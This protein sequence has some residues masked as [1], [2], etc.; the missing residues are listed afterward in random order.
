[1]NE[2]IIIYMSFVMFSLCAFFIIILIT[3]NVRSLKSQKRFHEI[4]QEGRRNLLKATI[5]GQE[6]ERK[7]IAENL[8]DDIGPLLSSLKLQVRN[9][10]YDPPTQKV[11]LDTID[12]AVGEIRRVLQKLSPLVF[13]ELGL[14]ESVRHICNEFK[15]LSKLA[16]VLKWD[17]TIEASLDREKKLAIFRI[18][19]EALNNILKHAHATD[20]EIIALMKGDGDWQIDITDNGI[21][22]QLDAGKQIGLGMSSMLARAESMNAKLIFTSKGKGASLV[23]TIPN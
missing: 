13:E 23:L 16:L 7:S 18:I 12:L 6:L 17:D 5:E 20:V 1:M 9:L 8:H 14:N 4:E 19:Q 2:S 22:I 21:G 15:K 11:F 3:W 10:V